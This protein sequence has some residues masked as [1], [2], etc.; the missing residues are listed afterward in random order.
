MPLPT[1]IL[2]PLGTVKIPGF[3]RG[4]TY[5]KGGEYGHG[6]SGGQRKAFVEA[7]EIIVGVKGV[8]NLLCSALIL[9]IAYCF[10]FSP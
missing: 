5:L 8:T 9:A 6:G 10:S 1:V 2:K 7:T 3:T 4:S